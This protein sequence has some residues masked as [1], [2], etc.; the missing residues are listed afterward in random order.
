[1]GQE[2]HLLPLLISVMGLAGIV[3]WHMQGQGRPTQR[4]IVQSQSSSQ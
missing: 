1:M 4:L 3:I 2:V